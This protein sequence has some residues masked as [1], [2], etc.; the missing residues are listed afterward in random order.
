MKI[1]IEPET[2]AEIAS[3]NKPVTMEGLSGLAVVGIDPSRP[4]QTPAYFSGNLAALM[5]R[6]PELTYH[7]TKARF[8]ADVAQ[9]QATPRIQVPQA[10]NIPFPKTN[11]RLRGG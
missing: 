6:I 9:A 7:L 8:A 11:D 10:D 2:E 5:Q 4:D 1:T 3:G